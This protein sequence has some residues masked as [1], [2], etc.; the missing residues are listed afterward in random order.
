MVFDKPRLPR[1]LA[2]GG[3]SYGVFSLPE[4]GRLMRVQWT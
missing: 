1:V 3:L 2:P 4:G